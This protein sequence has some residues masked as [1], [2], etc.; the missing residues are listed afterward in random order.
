MYTELKESKPTSA[1][2]YLRW[3]TKILL[4][5]LGASVQISNAALTPIQLS[6]ILDRNGWNSPGTYSSDGYTFVVTERPWDLSHR[7]DHQKWGLASSSTKLAA[8]ALEHVDSLSGPELLLLSYA[9]L[10]EFNAPINVIFDGRV[11]RRYRNV[12]VT[13][14]DSLRDYADKLNVESLLTK[15][16]E[17]VLRDPSDYSSY[18]RAANLNEVPLLIQLKELRSVVRT[19]GPELPLT[20]NNIRQAKAFIDSKRALLAE[21]NDP[22]LLSAFECQDFP[23]KFRSELADQGITLFSTRPAHNSLVNR[24]KACQGFTTFDSTTDIETPDMWNRITEL[25]KTGTDLELATYLLEQSAIK[26]PNDPLIWEYLSAAYEAAGASNDAA[27]IDRVWFLTSAEKSETSVLA[28]ILRNSGNANA[29][30]ILG[31]REK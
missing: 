17:K 2:Y 8:T 16:A 9:K 5:S 18:F 10:P 1:H 19:L 7:S 26:S 3:L 15:T 29:E 12:I 14:T 31:R 20:R 23:S 30:F 11:E 4:I 24:I 22:V 25:F 28:K 27:I 21:I 6:E 13:S